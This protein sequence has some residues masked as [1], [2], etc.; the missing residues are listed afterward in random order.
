MTYREKAAA[1]AKM[2]E[3]FTQ[4][5]AQKVQRTL[6]ERDIQK[7]SVDW[8]RT[9]GWWAR[10]FSSMSQRSV[11]DVLFAHVGFGKFACEFKAPGK[12]STAAQLD[13]QQ[14]MR[15]SGWDVVEIDSVAAFKAYVTA[16]PWHF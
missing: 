1:P 3:A 13:E 16:R 15:D 5:D 10:K 8:A 2:K 12:T 7:A 6:R 9:H 11:P 4:I 14:K